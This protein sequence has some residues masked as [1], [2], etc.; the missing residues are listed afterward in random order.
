MKQL[1]TE[2]KNLKL[3]IGE[4]NLSLGKIFSDSTKFCSSG[5]QKIFIRT[6]DSVSEPYLLTKLLLTEVSDSEIKFTVSDEEE[7]FFAELSIKSSRHGS[8]INNT[9]KI[10]RIQI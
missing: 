7:N 8:V 10:R 9:F 2:N 6:A 4:T 5:E 3:A 1:S